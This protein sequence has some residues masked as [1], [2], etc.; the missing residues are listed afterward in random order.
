MADPATRPLQAVQSVMFVGSDRSR[1]VHI[2]VPNGNSA[3]DVSPPVPGAEIAA[4]ESTTAAGS[5]TR[6]AHRTASGCT[7]AVGSVTAT[8]S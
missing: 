6:A 2:P 5:A 8:E 3:K 1:A 7:A 4:A